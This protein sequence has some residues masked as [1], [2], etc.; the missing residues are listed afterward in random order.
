MTPRPLHVAREARYH[1]EGFLGGLREHLLAWS[2]W[3]F[4]VGGTVFG[5]WFADKFAW[6]GAFCA[7]IGLLALTALAYENHLQLRQARRAHQ[8]VTAQTSGGFADYPAPSRRRRTEVEPNS[9]E[10]SGAA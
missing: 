10:H 1:A 7:L 5:L 3:V 4:T 8:G 9:G 6:I 2:G